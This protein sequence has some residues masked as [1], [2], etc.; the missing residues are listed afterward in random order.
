[1]AGWTVTVLDGATPWLAAAAAAMPDFRRPLT[2]CGQ[3]LQKS[4][5]RQFQVEGVPHWQPLATSTLMRRRGV[6]KAVRS[7]HPAKGALARILQDTGRLRSSYISRTALGSIYALQPTR[8]TIGSNLVYSRIHQHGG[9]AGRNLATFIPARPLAILDEDVKQ[10]RKIFEWH[11][12]R[13]L[14][15]QQ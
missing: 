5:V 1:M 7:K 9:W 4:F 6:K 15:Q 10:F 14:G 11:A 12:R 2:N 3:H 13:A 8:L